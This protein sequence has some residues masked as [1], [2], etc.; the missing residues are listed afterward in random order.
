MGKQSRR[1]RN[2]TGKH[3]PSTC[4]DKFAVLIVTPAGKQFMF[5]N[6]YEIDDDNIQ[7]WFYDKDANVKCIVGHELTDCEWI[8]LEAA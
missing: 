8:P 6:H 4:K 3:L 5:T 1:V 2:R 7:E